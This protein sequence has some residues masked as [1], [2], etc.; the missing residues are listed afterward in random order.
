MN[1]REIPPRNTENLKTAPVKLGFISRSGGETIGRVAA[2]PT[3]FQFEEIV[4]YKITLEVVPSPDQKKI[5]SFKYQYSG[6]VPRSTAMNG[7]GTFLA[8]LRADP[9][10]PPTTPFTEALNPPSVRIIKKCFVVLHLSEDWNWQFTPAT[11]A[12]RTRD[13]HTDRYCG[14][15]HVDK[16][17]NS[18]PDVA[19]LERT[20]I[21]YF[22]VTDPVPR[23]NDVTDPFNLSVMLDGILHNTQIVIDPDIK[24]DGGDTRN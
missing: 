17:G 4:Y 1:T 20:N 5:L 7:I 15:V 9:D 11:E 18:S 10:H 19:G 22:A 13:Q 2:M 6:S 14:L 24:N 21:I 3:G 16:N 12:L 8:A 23:E